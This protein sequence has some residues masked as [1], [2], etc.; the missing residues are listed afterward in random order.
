MT[1]IDIK[2]LHDDIIKLKRDVNVIKHIL[3]EEGELTEWA[4]KALAE[5]RA[6][7]E[8]EYTNLDDV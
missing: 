5:A 8:K 4:K 2:H 6:E 7:P 3:S 1:E